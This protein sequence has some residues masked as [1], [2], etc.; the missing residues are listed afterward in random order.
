MCRSTIA[1]LSRIASAAGPPTK[2]PAKAEKALGTP[3]EITDPSLYAPTVRLSVI[4]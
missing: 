2:V 3:F 1:R 4:S